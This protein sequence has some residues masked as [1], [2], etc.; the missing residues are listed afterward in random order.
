MNKIFIMI[1]ISLLTACSTH[2]ANTSSTL[3]KETTITENIPTPQF[4]QRQLL[5]KLLAMM[6]IAHSQDDFTPERVSQVFGVKLRTQGLE[7]GEFLLTENLTS[8]WRYYFDK[9]RDGISKEHW[10]FSI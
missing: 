5:T 9:S 4:T 1:L 2:H 8:D 6:E 10:F 3:N 7:E